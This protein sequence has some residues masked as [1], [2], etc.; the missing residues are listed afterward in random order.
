MHPDGATTRQIRAID[1]PARELLIE[2]GAGSGKT[3]VLS[4]AIISRILEGKSPSDFLVV[5]FTRKA[6]AEMKGRISRLLV[7]TGAGTA[8]DVQRMTIGTFHA[9]ALRY[10]MQFGG[11]IGYD[12]GRLVIAE[13]RQREMLL[14][15]IVR[16]MG[17]CNVRGDLVGGINMGGIAATL[18]AFY[19]DMVNPSIFA[20]QYAEIMTSYHQRMREMNAVDFGMILTEFERLMTEAGDEVRDAIHRQYSDIFLDESQDTDGR[21]YKLQDLVYGG[22]GPGIRPARMFA[23]GDRRQSI[24]GWRGARP[25]HVFETYPEAEVIGLPDNFRSCAEIVDC[26]NRLIACDPTLGKIEPMIAHKA[27]GLVEEIRGGTEDVLRRLIEQAT[28]R[29]I[30]WNEVA[31]LART[32]AQLRRVED[33]WRTLDLAPPLYRVGT[34]FS[35]V[36]EDPFTLTHSTMQAGVNIYDDLA[37]MSLLSVNGS[38][39]LLGAVRD[40]AMREGASYVEAWRDIRSD[41]PGEEPLLRTIDVLDET[42]TGDWRTADILD[43]FAELLDATTVDRLKEFWRRSPSPLVRLALRWF[44]LRDVQDDVPDREEDE[45]AVA[46]TI[47]AS[48]G[49]EWDAGVVMNCNEYSIPSSRSITDDDVDAE[50]RVLYVA[51]TRFRQYLGLH[52]RTVFADG[53]PARAPSRFLAEMIG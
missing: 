20:E 44:A 10:L 15:H 40:R 17:L 46:M 48:K 45:L 33:V 43:R 52:V 47:H 35:I 14:R 41:F 18:E 34:A 50:R 19:T 26:A 51:V 13:P 1:S 37:A 53:E 16:L 32:H 22:R 39:E 49:L 5:T 9:I 31:I 28:E 21:Q 23:V 11:R 3:T 27:G 25:E 24:Y 36:E 7:S 12:A 42:T 30:R 8:G 6:A 38:D 4:Y 29:E 2:A